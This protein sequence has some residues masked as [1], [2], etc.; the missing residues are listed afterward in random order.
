MQPPGNSTIA[1][2]LACAVY[3][4]DRIFAPAA[5]AF[6]SVAPRSCAWYPVVS[7]DQK[8]MMYER[9][10]APGFHDLIFRMLRDVR[11]V[12]NVSQTATEISTLTSLIGA[13]MGIAILPAHRQSNIVLLRLSL[14]TF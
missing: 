12:P 2:V 10:Y 1:V 7:W 6:S 5:L 3:A 4:A 8:F 14:V 9:T 13:H 11:I